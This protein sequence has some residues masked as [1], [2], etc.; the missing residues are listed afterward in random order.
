M[1]LDKPNFKSQPRMKQK[2]ES[3]CWPP[4][5]VEL[6][7]SKKQTPGGPCGGDIDPEVCGV[8]VHIEH[9]AYGSAHPWLGGTDVGVTRR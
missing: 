7:T 6:K 1:A 5:S 4:D 3:F 8:Q 9:A 2:T